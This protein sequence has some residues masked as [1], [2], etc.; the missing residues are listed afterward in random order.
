M[1]ASPAATV[2]TSER[3]DLPHQ[4]AEEGGEGH[5]IDVDREQDQLDRHQDD[6]DVLAIEKNAEDADGEQDRGNREIMAEPD[7]HGTSPPSS[8][9]LARAHLA[10]SM[11]LAG[12][13]A[14]CVRDVLAL[15]AV[16]WRSVSTMA[17]IMATSS[18]SPA[19]WK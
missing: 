15:D 1:A 9:A 16:L 3:E 17:P 4:I 13:R 10:I 18:T 12:S 2:S 8:D 5:E 7:G 14:F 6:D 11:A 19:I